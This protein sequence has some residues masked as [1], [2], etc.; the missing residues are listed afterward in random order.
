[1]SLVLSSPL[2][3]LLRTHKFHFGLYGFL[4]HI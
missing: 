2:L 1:L 4:M 3:I